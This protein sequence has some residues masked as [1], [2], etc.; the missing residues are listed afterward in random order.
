M[1]NGH[2]PKSSRRLAKLDCY[3]IAIRLRVAA[4]EAVYASFAI[5]AYCKDDWKPFSLAA[6]KKASA[7]GPFPWPIKNFNVLRDAGY[8]ERLDLN[9]RRSQASSD[10]LYF[11]TAEFK[12]KLFGAPPRL[13]RVKARPIPI[14]SD[15]QLRLF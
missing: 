7:A 2:Y 15:L 5:V 1:N 6:I 8:V 11:A 14:E 12:R 10:V 4:E 9:D 3:E 13:A